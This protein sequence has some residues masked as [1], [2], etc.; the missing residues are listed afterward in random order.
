MYKWRREILDTVPD[1]IV[2]I[3]NGADTLAKLLK[4]REL[5]NLGQSQDKPE[6][7]IIGRVRMRM[8]IIGNLRLPWLSVIISTKKA[9]KKRCIQSLYYLNPWGKCGYEG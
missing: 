1:A 8:V 3:L 4:I 6:F 9:K 5:L 2:W 7:F